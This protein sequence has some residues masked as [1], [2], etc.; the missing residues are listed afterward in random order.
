[1]MSEPK[2]IPEE[3]RYVSPDGDDGATGETRDAP[4]KTI[5]AAYDALVEEET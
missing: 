1:M 3:R 5:Q 2:P 4:M